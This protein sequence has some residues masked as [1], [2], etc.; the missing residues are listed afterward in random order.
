MWKDH[1]RMMLSPG[2]SVTERQADVLAAI[3]GYIIFDF[4][5]CLTNN[6]EPWIMKVHHS[7]CIFLIVLALTK[8]NCGSELILIYAVN[9]VTNL[10]LQ[11]RW[12]LRY[13]GFNNGGVELLFI[14]SF[15]YE[16]IWLSFT[17]FVKIARSTSVSLEFKLCLIIHCLI[18][19]IFS[20]HVGLLVL[21]K[22]NRTCY[23]STHKTP[24]RHSTLSFEQYESPDHEDGN[25]HEDISHEDK[26]VVR[27]DLSHGDSHLECHYAR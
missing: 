17:L 12:F 9:Q 26:R 4:I 7:I 1:M 20:Y 13:H 8:A 24:P 22:V 23:G 16:R 15:F 21:N 14:I 25:K 6:C 18:G 27:G 10:F 2:S 11:L 5:W 19:Y 3:L